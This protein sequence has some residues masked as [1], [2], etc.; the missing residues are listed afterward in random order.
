[1]GRKVSHRD[2]D[3]PASKKDHPLTARP[4]GV[5]R[6]CAYLDRPVIGARINSPIKRR[7][8]IA[9]C[10]RNAAMSGK[11]MDRIDRVVRSGGGSV[12]RAALDTDIVSGSR[13]DRRARTVDFRAED[14]HSAVGAMG[15][16]P[17]RS[18]TER[19]NIATTDLNVAAGLRMDAVAAQSMGDDCVRTDRQISASRSIDAIAVV[20][21]GFDRPGRSI[22]STVNY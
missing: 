5:N 21:V 9:A 14:R 16:N 11:R 6:V 8:Q 13:D 22:E 2:I 3:V 19:L 12:D 10:D 4:G 17:V 18:S 15:F 1:M 20:A 7:L